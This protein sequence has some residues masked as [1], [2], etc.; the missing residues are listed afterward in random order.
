MNSMS[1]LKLSEIIEPKAEVIKQLLLDGEYIIYCDVISPT[2]L[3]T[4]IQNVIAI[5]E[6]AGMLEDRSIVQYTVT[7]NPKSRKFNLHDDFVIPML[8][9]KIVDNAIQGL[10]EGTIYLFSI[11]IILI[12]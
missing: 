1:N 10:L 7:N 3:K 9:E 4:Y 2:D 11:K 5:Q 8:N 12:G 6:R